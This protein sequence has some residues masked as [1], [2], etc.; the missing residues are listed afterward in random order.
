[1]Q[2]IT[3]IMSGKL[4]IFAAPSGSGKTTIIKRLLAL[5]YPL[6]FSISATTRSPR[7]GEIDGKDY[8]FLSEADFR[9]HIEERNFVE[10]EEVYS[11]C[12][13][14]T[15][16]SEI[17]KHLNQGEHVVFDVDVVGA[18]NIKK[19]YRERALA[20]FVMPPSLEVLKERLLIRASESEE[21]LQMRLAKAAHEMSFAPQFDV[22]VCNDDYDKARAEILKLVTDF[23]EE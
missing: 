10:W 5:G 13:Y 14:G 16:K 7:T 11:G 22:I 9:K 2:V 6:N 21:T 19:E 20:I 4:I 17:E 3:I 18:L 15:L 8:H 1:M 23:I 12:F